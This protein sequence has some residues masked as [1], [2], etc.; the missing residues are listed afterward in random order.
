VNEGFGDLFDEEGLMG[1]IPFDVT[2]DLVVG[3]LEVAHVLLYL[4]LGRVFLLS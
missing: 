4:L 3:A 2:F 1:D